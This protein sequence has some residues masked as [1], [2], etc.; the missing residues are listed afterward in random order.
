MVELYLPSDELVDGN[1]AAKQLNGV[2]DAA[3]LLPDSTRELNIASALIHSIYQE[4][5]VASYVDEVVSQEYDETS[6]GLSKEIVGYYLDALRNID[7]LANFIK[8]V[9]K[10][11]NL[12]PNERE[13]II[14]ELNVPA[15]V[16]MQHHDDITKFLGESDLAG[17]YIDKVYSEEE[18]EGF[19][20]YLSGKDPLEVLQLAQDVFKAEQAR[21]AFWSLRITGYEQEIDGQVISQKGLVDS[22]SP[23]VRRYIRDT[24]ATPPAPKQ[25]VLST[26]PIFSVGERPEIGDK[27]GWEKFLHRNRLYDVLYIHGFLPLTNKEAYKVKGFDSLKTDPEAI[28]GWVDMVYESNHRMEKA[29]KQETNPKGRLD[30]LVDRYISY[31]SDALDNI[32]RADDLLEAIDAK[33]DETVLVKDAFPVEDWL[34]DDEDMRLRF[35]RLSD[36]VATEKFVDG[37]PDDNIT[38]RARSKKLTVQKE[39]DFILEMLG[40]KSVSK[41]AEIADRYKMDQENRYKYW[42]VILEAIRPNKTV[43]AKIDEKL[44]YL[45]AL[46]PRGEGPVDPV[47]EVRPTSSEEQPF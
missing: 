35:M 16:K 20:E 44:G 11:I 13:G 1:K 42:R 43:S 26:D 3:K 38:K 4:D 7:A 34:R 6:L 37:G 14:P 22:D 25:E 24:F 5:G 21:A 39:I 40:D 29:K 31:A 19:I 2:Y 36:F 47:I 15:L 17:L 41:L 9:D 23:D 8:I 28:L 30:K 18:R 33:P 12:A 10:R 45:S 27:E 46:A 32:E